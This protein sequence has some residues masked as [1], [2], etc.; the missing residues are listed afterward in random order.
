PALP[1][2]SSPPSV[3]SGSTSPAKPST[4]A[5]MISPEARGWSGPKSWPRGVPT[6][7]R[8]NRI[9]GSTST[10][11]AWGTPAAWKNPQEASN[12]T[13]DKFCPWCESA[14]PATIARVD[15]GRDWVE[16]RCSGC[17][18]TWVIKDGRPGELFAFWPAD[19]DAA[20]QCDAAPLALGG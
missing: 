3:R 12:I 4:A 9:R 16:W 15:E 5:R 18:M 13:I 10:A 2:R 6:A 17:G 8:D 19:I 14:Q 7:S 20:L 1:S 11:T